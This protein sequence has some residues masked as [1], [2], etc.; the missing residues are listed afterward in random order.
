MTIFREYIIAAIVAAVAFYGLYEYDMA[1]RL[2]LGR[3]EV[4]TGYVLFCLMIFLGLFNSRKKLSMVPLGRAAHWLVLH[5][6]VGIFVL[7]AFW[8]HTRS[9]W[10]Q[11]AYEQ[12]LAG[13]F[14]IVSL[15]GICGFVLQKIYPPRLTRIGYEVIYE[16]IPGELADLRAEAEQ[17]VFDATESSGDDTLARYYIENLQWFFARPRFLLSHLFGNDNPRH[18]LRQQFEVVG[19]YLSGSEEEFLDRLADLAEKKVKIDNHYAVQSLLK[20]W[21]LLHLP[22]SVGLILLSIWHLIIVNIYAL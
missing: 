4:T 20:R 16:R 21:L 2:N 18:W 22:L 7:L 9:F 14:Y 8:L 6:V 19:R 12:V 17:A 3:A 1:E 15:S 5:V 11:G 13:L 10:P